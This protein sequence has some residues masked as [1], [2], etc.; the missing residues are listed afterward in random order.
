MC[1]ARKLPGFS[2]E[3]EQPALDARRTGVD[4]ERCLWLVH[5]VSVMI[6]R[7][8]LLRLAVING[9]WIMRMPASVAAFLE[10][11]RIAVAGVS[12]NSAQPANAIFRR[13]KTSGYDVFPINPNATEVEGV[14]CYRD[15][16]SVPEPLDGVVIATPPHASIEIVRQ[17]SGR[18][19]GEPGIQA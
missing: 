1:H 18:L 9:R 16:G 15:V 14:R 6:Q 8:F 3:R 11:R 4:C 7:A 2:L 19:R 5:V 10:G 17:C 12:R 13:L